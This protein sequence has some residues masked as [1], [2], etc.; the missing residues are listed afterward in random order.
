MPP[1]VATNI[2]LESEQLKSLKRLAVEKGLSLSKLFRQMISEY[3]ARG[4]D[5]PGKDWRKDPFFSLG[6]KP[7]RSGRKSISEEHNAYLYG[8]LNKKP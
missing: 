8:G 7:G 4:S 1:I 5:V 6:L 2:R 3:L